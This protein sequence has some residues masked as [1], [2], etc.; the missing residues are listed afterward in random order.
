MIFPV[1]N[2][3][4]KIHT[5]IKAMFR[6]SPNLTFTVSQ[7]KGHLQRGYHWLRKLTPQQ[8]ALLSK[9]IQTGI[10]KFIQTGIVKKVSSNVSVESQWQL[11]SAVA[12]SGYT[13]VTSDDE[14][15]Q[16]E[17]AR[18]A[19]ERRAVGGKSLWVLNGKACFGQLHKA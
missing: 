6:S 5:G 17:E 9:L 1:E 14:V 13:N 15:A 10:K 19:A 8:D 11:A 18:K 2:Y 4:D 3:T 16:T 7:M 12:D